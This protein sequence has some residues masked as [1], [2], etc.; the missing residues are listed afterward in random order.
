[1]AQVVLQCLA[2]GKVVE[3]DGLGAFYP[4]AARGCRFEPSGLQQ[5]LIAYV[6]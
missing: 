2:A 4:D 6:K 3:I 1:L 5:V